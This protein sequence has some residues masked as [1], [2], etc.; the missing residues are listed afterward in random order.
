MPSLFDPLTA[1]PDY[2][3]FLHFFAYQILNIVTPI[4]KICESLTLILPNLNNFHSQLQM[5]EIPIDLIG[6]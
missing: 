6:G 1:C 5:G 3:I 4:S 2:I